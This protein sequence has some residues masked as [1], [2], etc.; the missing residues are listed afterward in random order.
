MSAMANI[1][2]V[3]NTVKNTGAKEKTPKETNDMPKAS[4]L[5]FCEKHYEDIL[6]IIMDRVRHDKRREVQTRPNFEESPKKTQRARDDSQSLSD[7]SPPARRAY[8]SDLVP[9]TPQAQQ[10]L[11][12]AG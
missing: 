8:S 12:Q 2:P 6:P 5:Y 4:I 9:L 1:T 10:S 11:D 7:G 3:I